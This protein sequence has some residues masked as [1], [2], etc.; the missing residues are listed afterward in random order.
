MRK[1][2]V[3][4]CAAL[5]FPALNAWAQ[6]DEVRYYDVEVLVFEILDER[7]RRAE[8]WPSDINREPPEKTV[9]LGKPI[10]G[11]MPA[12]WNPK[13]SFKSLP[14]S[15]RRLNEPRKLMENTD[16]Y[17][18]LLHRNW[19]Q[20]GLERDIAL[21]VHFEQT[22]DP[23]PV[24]ISSQTPDYTEVESPMMSS[25]GGKS[26]LEGYIKIILSRYLHAQVDLAY[27]NNV[28][29]QPPSFLGTDFM[30]PELPTPTYFRLQQTRRM[31]SGELHYLDHPA[32]G[33]LILITPFEAEGNAG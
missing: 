17:R 30:Q 11:P 26:M 23:S 15:E 31:R 7:S 10:P 19:R 22:Y 2:F 21:P 4:A 9:E 1:R 20:P 13:W 33:I 27:V 18:I 29:E 3:L 24:D 6:S 32:L 28:V 8:Q 12:S 14:D 16:N 25:G 5:L